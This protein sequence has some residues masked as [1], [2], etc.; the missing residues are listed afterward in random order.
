VTVGSA[1]AADGHVRVQLLDSWP[2]CAVVPAA[3]PDGPVLRTEPGR[4]P[5]PVVMVLVPGSDG[6]RIDSAGRLA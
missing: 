5:V 1:P 6:W 4:A 2:E 3:T